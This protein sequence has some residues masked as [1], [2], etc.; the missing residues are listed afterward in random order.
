MNRNVD[1]FY[2]KKIIYTCS[3]P[4]LPFTLLDYSIQCIAVKCEPEFTKKGYDFF[5]V[6]MEGLF[7]PKL[8]DINNNNNEFFKGWIFKK[9]NKDAIDYFAMLAGKSYSEFI[10]ILE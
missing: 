3:N 1:I 7:N 10:K 9:D 2:P 6:Q 4:N 5:T 8:S